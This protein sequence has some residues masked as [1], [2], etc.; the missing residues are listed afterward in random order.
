MSVSRNK[1][2][3]CILFLLILQISVSLTLFADPF[4]GGNT[5]GVRPQAT[6]APS[7]I[8]PE[9]FNIFQL[10]IREKS[11]DLL[12]VLRNNPSPRTVGM[13]L[14]VVFFYGILHGAG[15][16][17]RKTV[18]FTLF[19]SRPAGKW[20]PMAAGFLSAG[21]HAGTSLLLFIFFNMIWNSVSAFSDSENVAFY[22]E[23]W[24]FVVLS[25]FALVLV[26]V[27]IIFIITGHS[28]KHTE[29]K[30]KNIYL[31]LIVSS[32]F[33]CPGATMLLILALSQNLIGMGIWGVLAMS[34]GMGIIISLAGYLGM[35]GRTRIF[36]W[37]KNRE[38]VVEK[39]N[40]TFE[41]LSYSI[42]A[43]FS[44]WMGSPFIY[45]LLRG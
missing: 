20:E 42:I 34:L 8:L 14:L 22:L 11:A 36:T 19:L 7:G 40:S 38:G 31:L 5:K 29:K 39:I 10:E 9:G 43:A 26:I 21:L 32:L 16:G 23:G 13:F 6:R 24:T 18:I 33:P 15:P 12:N 45:W 41:L 17:H 28:H 3:I 1:I 37:F 4:T 44:L 30:G 35:T 2:N 27:K 25:V